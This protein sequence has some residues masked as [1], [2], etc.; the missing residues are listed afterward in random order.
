MTVIT[1]AIVASFIVGIAL[2]VGQLIAFG[3]GEE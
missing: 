3:M 1:I 2:I